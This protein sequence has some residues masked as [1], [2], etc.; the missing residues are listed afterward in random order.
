MLPPLQDH[1]L[2]GFNFNIEEWFEGDHYETLAICRTLALAR[3][4]FAAAVAEK[5][6]CRL[7]IRS[8][9]RVVKR[10]PQGDR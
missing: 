6:A 3:A 5:P 1:W 10:H 8:R 2:P 7:M 4:A 9:I